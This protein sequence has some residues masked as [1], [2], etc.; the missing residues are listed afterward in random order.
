MNSKLFFYGSYSA[1]MM[2]DTINFLSNE[3]KRNVY[4]SLNIK[5][6]PLNI[7]LIIKIIIRIISFYL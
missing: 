7:E 4:E 6:L 2:N 3:H 5:T 1:G